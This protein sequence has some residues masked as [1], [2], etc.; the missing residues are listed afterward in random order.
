MASIVTVSGRP[1]HAV[2]DLAIADAVLAPA[3]AYVA[4]ISPHCQAASVTAQCADLECTVVTTFHVE[5]VPRYRDSPGAQ[6]VLGQQWYRIFSE[7]CQDNF[8]E[9]EIV[10]AIPNRE[11]S[12]I[13][14]RRC[15][16]AKRK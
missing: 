2:L 16:T 13:D 14:A 3:F 6:L 4:G 1:V 5:R 9:P 12:Q 15:N 7:W 11:F 8:L 10:L